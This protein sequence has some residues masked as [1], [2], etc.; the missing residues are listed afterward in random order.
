M[1]AL[2]CDRLTR[3]STTSSPGRL[4]YLKREARPGRSPPPLSGSES[5]RLRV[6]VVPSRCRVAYGRRWLPKVLP[7][8]LCRFVSRR[9]AQSWPSRLL[10]SSRRPGLR[11]EA[12]H[13]IPSCAQ[14]RSRRGGAD[15]DTS[16]MATWPAVTGSARLTASHLR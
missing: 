2:C 16:R 14:Q 6:G 5:G 11:L 13:L 1:G 12:A 4:T 15:Q 9:A 3:C 8:P 10:V 7:G